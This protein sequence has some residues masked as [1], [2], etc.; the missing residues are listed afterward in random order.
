MT[1]SGFF[2]FWCGWAAALVCDHM[3]WRIAEKIALSMIVLGCGLMMSG[4]SVWLGEV[5]P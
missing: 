5:M 4:V 3:A 2:I 1:G